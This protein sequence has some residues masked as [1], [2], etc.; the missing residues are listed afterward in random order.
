MKK[1][2]LYFAVE[3]RSFLQHCRVV[4]FVKVPLEALN[5]ISPPLQE[6]EGVQFLL[7][8]LWSHTSCKSKDNLFRR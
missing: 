8:A 3:H 5:C 2:C 1:L 4:S 7:E 6:K